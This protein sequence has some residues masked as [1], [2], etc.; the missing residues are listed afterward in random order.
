MDRVL[1][2]GRFQPFHNGH[3]KVVEKIANN[4][5]ELIIVVGGTQLSYSKRHPFK[6]G[7]RIEMI[8]NS[9]SVE[10]ESVYIIPVSNIDNNALWVQHVENHTPEFSNVYTNNELVELLFEEEDYDVKNIDWV[11]RDN[12]SGTEFRRRII[13]GENWRSLVPDP[14]ISILEDKDGI[15]RIKR[16]SDLQG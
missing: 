2:V 8:K 12:L 9:I 1:Y 15:D 16:V 13:N 4:H 14:V 5:K 10:F 3:K 7:E 6:M 11:D